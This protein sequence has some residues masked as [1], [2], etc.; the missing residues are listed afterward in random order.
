MLFS[1]RAI[2]KSRIE[3]LSVGVPAGFTM[4][5]RPTDSGTRATELQKYAAY[6]IAQINHYHKDESNKLAGCVMTAL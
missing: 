3:R 4:R 1:A 2:M 5:G 6:I